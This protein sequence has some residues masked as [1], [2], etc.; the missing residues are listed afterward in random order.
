M[1]IIIVKALF[2]PLIHPFRTNNY[3]DIHDQLTRRYF[4]RFSGNSE[5][6]AS[7]LPENLEEIF[8]WYNMFKYSTTH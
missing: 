1:T 6:D 2:S 5:A 8:P 7:E 3:E 4:S